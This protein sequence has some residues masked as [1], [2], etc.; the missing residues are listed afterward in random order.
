VRPGQLDAL[1]TLVAEMVAGTSEEPGTR[2]YEWYISEDGSTVHGWEKYA[3]SE[4]T[5]T[6]V[7]GFAEKWAGRLTECVETHSFVVYGSPDDAVK[8]FIA[9]WGPKYLGVMGGFAR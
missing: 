4:A 9:D 5:L 1:K 3:D 2:N 8:E 7:K 6:H